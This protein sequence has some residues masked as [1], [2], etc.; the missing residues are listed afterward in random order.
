MKNRVGIVTFHNHE[1]YGAALQAFGLCRALETLGAEVCFVRDK[2]AKAAVAEQEAGV[3]PDLKYDKVAVVAKKMMQRYMDLRKKEFQR[4]VENYLPEADLTEERDLN[5]EFSCFVA[6]SDQVWNF[7]ITGADPF[8]FLDFA[9]PQKRISYAASFG[10]EEL[11][12]KTREWYYEQ[13]KDF[14]QISVREASGAGIIQELL[15]REAQI[16]PDP[17]LLLTAKEWAELVHDSKEAVVLYMTEFDSQLYKI[18]QERAKA[19]GC[20][21]VCISSM[22]SIQGLSSQAGGCGPQEWLSCFYHA[23]EVYTNSFHGTVFA[24][25]FHKDLYIKPLQKLAK[26]NNRIQNLLDTLGAVWKEDSQTKI[27]QISF[28]QN[29]D[30]VDEKISELRKVG[31][32]YLKKVLS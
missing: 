23:K 13:L 12:E 8:W 30:V 17:T 26:R 21:L 4:F 14:A 5:Q 32:N 31:M 6:G 20:Q 18:A 29:W 22:L 16:C 9:E 19:L 2:R 27:F 11:P 24:V 7:E 10:M 15:G 3:S 1:N 25:L 28:L